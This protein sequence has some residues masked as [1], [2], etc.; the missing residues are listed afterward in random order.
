[1]ADAGVG[2]GTKAM[3]SALMARVTALEK[4][5]RALREELARLGERTPPEVGP[6]PMETAFEGPQRYVENSLDHAYVSEQERQAE[7]RHADVERRR[8]A[9]RR[10]EVVGEREDAEEQVPRA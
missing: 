1:M 4:E 8:E 10:Q 7:S 9:E 5:V 3:L 6:Q 2:A